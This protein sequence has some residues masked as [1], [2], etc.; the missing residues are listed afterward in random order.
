MPSE[1]GKSEVCEG[2]LMQYTEFTLSNEISL[3]IFRFCWNR[4]SL[5]SKLSVQFQARAW[6]DEGHYENF[7]R[8]YKDKGQKDGEQIQLVNTI[9]AIAISYLLKEKKSNAE[10]SI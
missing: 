2:L 10:I 9:L 6:G 5:F 8:E 1:N 3:Q 7:L 4:S